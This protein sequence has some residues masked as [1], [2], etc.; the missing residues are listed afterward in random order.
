MQVSGPPAYFGSY[1]RTL[2]RITDAQPNTAQAARKILG[3]M[4]CAMRPLKW[5]EIQCLAS[6][7]E[8][9][10][11]EWLVDEARR[12]LINLREVCGS[13]VSELPGGRLDFVHVTTKEYVR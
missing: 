4:A 6:V 11:Q 1:E 13:L 2:L 7:Y 10:S 3:W 5:R 9:D 8:S 12:P